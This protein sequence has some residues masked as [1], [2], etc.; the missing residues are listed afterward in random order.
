VWRRSHSPSGLIDVVL[1]SDGRY[2]DAFDIDEND[3][4]IMRQDD[5]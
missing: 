2:F 5:R 1:K 4:M 3:L